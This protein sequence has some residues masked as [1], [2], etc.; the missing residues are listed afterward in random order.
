MRVCEHVFQLRSR[1]C[2][3]VIRT[4]LAAGSDRHGLRVTSLSVQAN[5]LHLI[6]EAESAPALSRGLQA[7]AVRLAR[8]LNRLMGRT[9]RVFADRYHAHVLRTP[10]EV[11]AALAY[12]AGNASRHAAQYGRAL[13]ASPRDPFTVGYFGERV[14]LPPDGAR[15]VAEPRTWLL[16]TGWRRAATVRSWTP[17]PA[18]DGPARTAPA[19]RP[20]R[21]PSA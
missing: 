11:R 9:E 4:A 19:A 14:L 20:A 8:G 5:H 21:R 12:V 17:R 2:F 13:A 7:L 10:R 18:L 1:R 3:A 6:V 15:M 16:C